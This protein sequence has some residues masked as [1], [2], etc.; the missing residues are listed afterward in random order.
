[1]GSTLLNTQ[2]SIE[3]LTVFFS[4]TS[5]VTRKH[6]CTLARILLYIMLHEGG[7][8]QSSSLPIKRLTNNDRPCSDDD[9][10]HANTY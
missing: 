10:V 8:A 7:G 5:V 1:L 4:I 9:V 3:I 6:H 2:Y